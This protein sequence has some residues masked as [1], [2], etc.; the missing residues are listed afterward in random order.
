MMRSVAP[1]CPRCP[2]W[3]LALTLLL[4]AAL[5]L[6]PVPVF[7][8]EPQANAP[9]PQF[10]G[11]GQ[12]SGR[13]PFNGP[14]SPVRSWLYNTGSAILSGP[15]VGADG[16]IYI[17]TEHSSVRAV[18]P[19]G[20]ER[21]AFTV[22]DGAG[23]PTYPVLT[24]RGRIIFGMPNGLIFALR[25]DG[26]E[27]WRFDT[28]HAPYGTADPQPVRGHPVIARNYSNL[29]F[30]TDGSNLYELDDGEY[31][32]VRRAADVIRAGAAVTPD[33]TIVWAS[34]DR[35][36]YAGR[37]TGGD[38]WRVPLDALVNGTPAVGADS[39]T[40]VATDAGSLY[41]IAT[42][43]SQR[44]RVRLGAGRPIRS[45]P[46]IA[47]DGTIYVGSDDGRLYALDPATG[48]E[49]WT[50]AT[51]GAL[52]ASPTIGANGTIYLGSTDATLYVLAP[53]GRLQS[54]FRVDSAIDFSSPAIGADGTLYVGT[55]GG[56]LHALREG[57]PAPAP[58]P[59]SAATAAPP[60]PA[61][62]P[63]PA[64]PSGRLPTERSSPRPGAIYFS[65]TGH[66]V[67]GAFQ[68]FFLARG[69]LEQFG[70]PLTEEFQEPSQDGSGQV[71]TVQYFQRARFEYHP[72]HA[73][74]PYEVQ[75]GLLGSE[76]LRQRGWLP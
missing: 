44:W 49:K 65:E 57:P 22:S 15:V 63:V 60:Q 66:N 62:A 64:A 71:F 70:Y 29:L 73:G 51:S 38:K 43:G 3:C 18:R 6:S 52:T 47:S 20:T 5:L 46:S 27:Q 14:S 17:A 74:T 33:G 72:E 9:W 1:G 21:W 41:A 55:R 23:T 56:G 12:R 16:T 36:L 11:D 53:D 75:L 4:A 2:T 50:F 39:T 48:N 59:P 54:A 67:S 25:T 76:L 69:G 7:A 19:D 24:N 10:K 32:G 34:Y 68:T 35:S 13:S 31:R 45:S 30:G 61:P 28:R 26:T 40:Y 37:A 58:A 42:D 8:D